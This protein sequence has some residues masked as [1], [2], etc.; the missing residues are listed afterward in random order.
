M[1]SMRMWLVSGTFMAGV[2]TAMLCGAGL[3][4]ADS[5]VDTGTAAPAARTAASSP[6]AATSAQPQP[7][8]RLRHS[9]AAAAGIVSHAAA[10]GTG[11]TAS[12]AQTS[13]T[14]AVTR[15][16][17]GR[18]RPSRRLATPVPAPK[19]V[20]P[21]P[22]AVDP[23]QFA[24][25]YYEQ[26]SVKQFFSIG[27]VNTKAVYTLNP[28]GTIRVQ[29]SGNYFFNGGPQS[30]IVGSAVPVNPNNTELS[31]SFLPVNSA[32]PPGNYTILAHAPDYS[33]V[34][35]SDPSGYSGYI[36]TRSKSLAPQD[37]QQL[38][39][40]ARDLGVR[41]PITPTTQYNP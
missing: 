5:G 28:D 9:A 30:S 39:A 38:V 13:A 18:G 20:V 17:P 26:G 34:I 8:A 11:S 24:G 22:D 19:P 29:N 31:V 4:S 36:L 32:T 1:T 40:Q 37:Y 10:A 25:T 21:S 12:A 14:A 33:W 15:P 41:G 2:G 7:G 16:T 35:V 27:L 3:A 23:A 6:A